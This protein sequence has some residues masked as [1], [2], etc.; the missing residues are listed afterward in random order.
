[1]SAHN[2]QPKKRRR[3]AGSSHRVHAQ[4]QSDQ[5]GDPQMMSM[6][7]MIDVVDELNTVTVGHCVARLYRIMIPAAGFSHDLLQHAA[8]RVVLSQLPD[9]YL[10]RAQSSGL[11]DSVTGSGNVQSQEATANAT[12]NAAVDELSG[13]AVD[14]KQVKL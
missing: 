1:M 14:D 11:M 5:V 13:E 2:D 8:R 9:A 3:T 6:Y 10:Q 4:S 7:P 12:V